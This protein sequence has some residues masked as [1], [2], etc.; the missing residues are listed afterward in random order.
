MALERLGKENA[1]PMTPT[2]QQQSNAPLVLPLGLGREDFEGLE[3]SWKGFGDRGKKD[4]DAVSVGEERKRELSRYDE[5]V[6]GL[7]LKQLRLRGLEGRRG[8]A[9]EGS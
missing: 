4:N 6:V 1:A 8:R 2:G 3:E 9:G 7:L 5:A